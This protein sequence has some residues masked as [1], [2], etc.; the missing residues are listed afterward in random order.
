[1]L[2]TK[3]VEKKKAPA[4]TYGNR[5]GNRTGNMGIIGMMPNYT[6]M[7]FIK[8]GLVPDIVINANCIPKHMIK[9]RAGN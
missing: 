8:S 4:S 6:D 3:L 5:T 7:L 1:M 9:H 2:N